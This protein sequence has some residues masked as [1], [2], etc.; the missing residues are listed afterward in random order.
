MRELDRIYEAED[1]AAA[2]GGRMTILIDSGFR[3]AG[4]DNAGEM[5]HARA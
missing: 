5:G 1:A 4:H 3:R 2:V